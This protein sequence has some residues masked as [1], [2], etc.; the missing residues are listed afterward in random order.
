MRP[1]VH[2]VQPRALTARHSVVA[3]IAAVAMGVSGCTV[4]PTSSNVSDPT[5]TSSTQ[6]KPSI[7]TSTPTSTTSSTPSA[8]SSSS[9]WSAELATLPVK[10]KLP[11]TNYQRTADFGP[12]W[13]DVSHDGCD[14]RNDALKRD[15][16]SISLSGSCEVLTGVL[17][18]PYTGKTI[19][20]VRGATTSTAVQIDHLVPLA[21]AWVE[22]AQS[23]TFTEREQMANDPI[24]LLAVDGPTNESKGDKDASA[25]LPAVAGF[26][27]PYV[28]KQIAVKVK[29]S[30]WVTQAEHDAM[31]RVLGTCGGG[32]VAPSAAPVVVAPAPA[33]VAPAPAAPPAAAVPGATVTGISPGAYCSPKG[34]VGVSK[35]GRSYICGSKGPDARGRF[36]WNA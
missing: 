9:P 2:D 15:L 7:A 33:P 32:G 30:L 14:P 28:E 5:H 22:G 10:P 27:C 13:T 25:W 12:A 1:E 3:I 31:V 4:T 34:A 19:H 20:F 11:L 17:Q 29:Y 16:T 8:A 6:S 18:D 23:L 36:H 21:N 24:E 26:D 35:A